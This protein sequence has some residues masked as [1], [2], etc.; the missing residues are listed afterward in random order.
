M[1]HEEETMTTSD[2]AAAIARVRADLIAAI[3]ANRAQAASRRRI[4]R[5]G[6]LAVAVVS[7]GA[8]TAVAATTGLFPPAPRD[9][10]RSF[11]QLS[12][13]GHQIDAGKAVAIGVIDEHAAYAAPTADGGFCLYFA[14]NPR[15]GP[16]GGTCLPQPVRPGDVAFSVSL[17]TDG[18]FVF[19]RAG[20][21]QA[22]SVDISFP[23][24]GGTLTARVGEQRFFLAR[25]TARAQHSLTVVV[26]PGPKDPPT[27]N[28][29]PLEVFDSDRIA[30]VT[31][32]ARNA[33][34][35]GIARGTAAELPEPGGNGTT[36]TTP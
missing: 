29:A 14:S 7:V 5:R 4:L 30:A 25:L 28:G 32:V 35:A 6:L 13:R 15:S 3:A 18:G 16:T 11:E 1:N 24:G 10:Q 12:T 36:T 26:E 27:K 8:T 22:R 21:A 33:S 20:D 34:G 19:G 31:A 2:P 17:G 9:A 23:Q